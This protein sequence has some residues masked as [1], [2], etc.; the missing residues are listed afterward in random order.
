MITYSRDTISG[1]GEVN[2]RLDMPG[3]PLVLLH[4]FTENNRMWD[5]LMPYLG[6]VFSVIRP[7]LPGHGESEFPESI[8]T[9]DGLADWLARFLKSLNIRKCYLAGHSLGGYIALATAE[10]YPELFEA[11]CLIHS[12]PLSDNEEK[13][14]NRERAIQFIESNGGEGFIQTL[15]PGLF[16]E[17]FRT[18]NPQAV[19]A[20]MDRALQTPDSTLLRMLTIM[21]NRP[22]R[23]KW[24]ESGLVP[25][26]AI[27][28]AQDNL[29]PCEYTA[30][31]MYHCP[32]SHVEVLHHSAHMGMQEEPQQVAK[33]LTL[34]LSGRRS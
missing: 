22:D 11:I 7:D 24:L 6:D 34:F 25:V 2:F 30:N 9:I 31:L 4:G 29:I 8:Q 23:L 21:R 5:S 20:S 32:D 3:V 28:G 33:A 18:Q 27:L 14:A 16:S 26:S 19:Q 1:I 10:K 13:K 15:I 12:T 17:N